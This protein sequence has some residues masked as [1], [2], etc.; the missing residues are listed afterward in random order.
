MNRSCFIPA[1]PWPCRMSAPAFCEPLPNLPAA[2]KIYE[3][4]CLGCPVGLRKRLYLVP[5]QNPGQRQS[6]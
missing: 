5:L 3:G 2:D 6:K 1:A 4:L